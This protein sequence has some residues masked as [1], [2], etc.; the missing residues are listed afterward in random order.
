MTTDTA[1]RNK[2]RVTADDSIDIEPRTR[3]ALEEPLTVVALDGTPV[4]DPGATV[5]LVVSHSGEQ[6]RVDARAGVC[7][8]PDSEHRD[9]DGGCKHVRRARAALDR[10]PLD[11]RVVAAVDVDEHLGANAPGPVVAASDGGTEII[12]AG[13]D[14]TIIDDEEDTDDG[15]PDDCDC[16]AWN[17]DEGLPCWPC[18]R[19]GF[20]EPASAE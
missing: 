1:A 3:R 8:C 16:G 5:V 6:Y 2:S 11:A 7:E 10:E 4:E 15:R 13:N 12:D 14:G 9:P 20:D 17:A 19:E 18:A